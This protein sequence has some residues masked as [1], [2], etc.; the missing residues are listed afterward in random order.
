VTAGTLCVGQ[1]LTEATGLLSGVPTVVET[2][3]FTVE[4]TDD[5][6]ATDSQ[7]FERSIVNPAPS[8]SVQAIAGSGGVILKFGT[9]AMDGSQLCEITVS[10]EEL[11]GTTGL[12]IGPV[13][14]ATSSQGRATRVV[15]VGGLTPE[16]RHSAS[17]ICGT[18]ASG[19]TSFTTSAAVGGTISWQYTAVPTAH[20]QS[21][22]AAKLKVYYALP[23]EAEASETDA[24][25]GS[26]CTV[27][28]SLTS[29][30]V[31]NIR[32]Q[33]LTAADAVLATT[34]LAP[35]VVP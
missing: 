15:T 11:D 20:L 9:P 23:G 32:H 31:Y 14:D 29:G 30:A 25:C 4:V 6:A 2:C 24:S 13:G 22:S 21:L 17:I 8:L 10:D 3:T 7:A 28:L 34:Q 18:V 33:W 12:P 1:T 35:V 27:V 26:G 16:H 19:S 5:A